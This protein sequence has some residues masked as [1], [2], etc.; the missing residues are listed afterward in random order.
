MQ[1]IISWG[2]VFS[3][4]KI[5]IIVIWNIFRPKSPDSQGKDI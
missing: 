3:S 2:Q 1:S 5:I 4:L